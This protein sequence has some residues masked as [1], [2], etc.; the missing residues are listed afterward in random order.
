MKPLHASLLAA[1]FAASVLAGTARAGSNDSQTMQINADE[2]RIAI[3]GYDTV[4][5]FTTGEPTLGS[6]DF[7]AKWEAATW[8]F[9][10]KE[11]RDA[12]VATP[13]QFAPQFGGFCVGGMA[14]GVRWTIDPENFAIVD[15][16]LYLSFTERGIEEL[17]TDPKSTLNDAEANWKTLGQPD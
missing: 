9:S 13:E 7:E 8:R 12:F 17:E 3:K 6:P 1:W 16:R 14:M 10:S 15:G 5:Y 11:H 4:A 2:A